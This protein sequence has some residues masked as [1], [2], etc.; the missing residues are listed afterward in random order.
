MPDGT[1]PDLLPGD[2]PPEEIEPGSPDKSIE[3]RIHEVRI[4]LFD[5][6]AIVDVARRAISPEDDWCLRHALEVVIGRIDGACAALELIAGDS[7]EA[8]QS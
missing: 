3:E 6:M 8:V 5:S 7:R 4:D 1:A 2:Q